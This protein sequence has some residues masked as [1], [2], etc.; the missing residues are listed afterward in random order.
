M[1]VVGMTR[2]TVRKGMIIWKAGQVPIF[3]RLIP[4]MVLIRCSTPM[5]WVQF[6]SVLLLLREEAGLLMVKIG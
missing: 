5:V 3:T 4:V 1:V 2:S 6:N